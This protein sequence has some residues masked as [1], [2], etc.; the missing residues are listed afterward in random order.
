LL[1]NTCIYEDKVL[2]RQKSKNKKNKGVV[3]KWE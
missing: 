3:D 1:I 2:E